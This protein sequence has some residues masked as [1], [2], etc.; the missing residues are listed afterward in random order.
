MNG[1]MDTAPD[2]V[3]LK[4]LLPTLIWDYVYD[5]DE[6]CAVIMGTREQ[7]GHFTREKLLQRMIE[8]L[9]WYDI[10]QALGIP[11]ITTFLSPAVLRGVRDASTRQKYDRVRKILHGEAVSAP[12]WDS[13]YRRSIEATLLSHRWYRTQ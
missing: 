9:R 1:H 3:F 10:V 13:E 2:Y 5:P 11:F 12:R 7:A 4:E 8:R 6:I